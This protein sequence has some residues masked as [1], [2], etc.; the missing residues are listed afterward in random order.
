MKTIIRPLIAI[1]LGMSMAIISGC[2]TEEC[3]GCMFGNISFSSGRNSFSDEQY[4]WENFYF[5]TNEVKGVI[6]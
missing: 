2:K 1:A 3:D 5:T 6:R 4:V